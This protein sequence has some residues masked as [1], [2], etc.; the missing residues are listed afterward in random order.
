VADGFYAC[1]HGRSR[2]KVSMCSA[3]RR[4]T[5]LGEAELAIRA[6]REAASQRA[7]RRHDAPFDGRRAAFFTV[8][9]TSI[10]PPPRPR[11]GWRHMVGSNCGNGLDAMIEIAAVVSARRP[12]TLAIQ[13]NAGLP[14]HRRHTRLSRVARF[15]AERVRCSWRR[16]C[17]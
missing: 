5:D 1:Q 12:D 2:L 16:V 7:H 13:A 6:A 15:F 4:W 3:S 17:S 11:P 10:A 8:M 14:E 9:G